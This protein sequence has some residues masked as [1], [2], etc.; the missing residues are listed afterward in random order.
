MITKLFEIRDR[1][2][3]FPLVAVEMAPG[4]VILPLNNANIDE[5]M[6]MDF[7]L[8]HCGYRRDQ[9]PLIMVFHANG[10]PARYDPHDWGDRTYHT[11]HKFIADNWRSLKSGAVI[12]VQFI[13]GE[14][15]EPV[16]SERTMAEGN[17]EPE[18]IGEDTRDAGK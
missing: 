8:V 15:S 6:A 9:P 14:T 4:P 1:S 7:L 10:G 12:D 2:T 11:A 3:F 16:T 18:A 17:L 5:W 13:L